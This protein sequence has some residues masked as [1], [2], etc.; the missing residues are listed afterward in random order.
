MLSKNATIWADSH[1]CD[2]APWPRYL[3]FSLAS[4]DRT[5]VT[6]VNLQLSRVS[7]ECRTWRRHIADALRAPPWL[8]SGSILRILMRGWGKGSHPFNP[9]RNPRK[10][11]HNGPVVS[12]PIGSWL[13]WSPLSYSPI[14]NWIPRVFSRNFEPVGISI[15]TTP[16]SWPEST[17]TPGQTLSLSRICAPRNVM[18]PYWFPGR[19]E[20]SWSFHPRQTAF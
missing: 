10:C 11:S 12:G 6:R 7:G 19:T 16:P 8:Y 4:N 5:S 9:S 14:A 18:A 13:S 2:M 20:S 17:I 15:P 1:P 3:S